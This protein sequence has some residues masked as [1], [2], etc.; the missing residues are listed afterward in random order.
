MKAYEFEKNSRNEEEKP[1]STLTK[2]LVTAE[3]PLAPA[4]TK[5]ADQISTGAMLLFVK[6]FGKFMKKNY[7]N[8]TSNKV[9]SKTNL[10]CFNCDRTSHFL[11]DCWRPKRDTKQPA[12]KKEREDGRLSKKKQ[13]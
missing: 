8:S 6:R 9:D 12:E 1:T 10:K 13:E 3:E 7:S 4:A 5:F 2:A 11:A